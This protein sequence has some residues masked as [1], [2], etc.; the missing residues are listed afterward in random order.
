MAYTFPSEEWTAAYKDAVNANA[1]YKEAGK[2]WTHGPVA[3]VVAKE[4]SLDINEEYVMILD[5]DRGSCRGAKLA[6]GMT[7][8]DEAPFIIVGK[9]D[10]WREVIEG[11]L[12]PT[13]A[14]LTGKLALTKGHLPTMIRYVESSK[15]LVES[16]TKV[17]TEFLD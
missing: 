12:D 16:A 13:K 17:P 8:A 14:M 15:Q 6:R 7:A 3:M 1:A 9:Y 5:V 4:P 10:R 2:D 11:K